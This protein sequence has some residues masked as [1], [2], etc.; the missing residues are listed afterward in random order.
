MRPATWL[1]ERFGLPGPA[2]VT[3]PVDRGELGQ[4]W[5]LTTAGR[6]YAVK[7]TFAPLDGEQ[8]AAAYRLQ[9]AATA[10]GVVT[11]EQLL[12]IDGEPAARAENEMLRVY[13]W[14]ELAPADR[15]LDPAAV[16]RTL[17]TLHRVGTEVAPATA[18]EVDGWYREPVGRPRWERLSAELEAARA[19]F[20]AD[21]AALVDDLVANEAVMRPPSDIIVGH[22]DL[23]ADNVR[24]GADGALVVIDW[25][26]CGPTSAI[27]ELAMVLVEFAATAERVRDLAEAYAEAGGP[28]RIDS[29]ADFTM[30]MAVLG[31]LVELGARQWLAAGD[32]LA[33]RRAADRVAEFTHDP[34]GCHQAQSL[35]SAL[36]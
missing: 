3:G 31:H 2:A 12:T 25:D 30:P 18:G 10:A 11:P 27:G 4:V 17:A 20:A 8:V 26:N 15:G 28:A 35:L 36:T 14:T 9:R 33:R 16:G 1:A 6:S 22:R 19:P 7:E 32:P 5:R 13:A 24:A 34:F 21:L 23:W 29:L